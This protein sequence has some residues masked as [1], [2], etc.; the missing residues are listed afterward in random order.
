MLVCVMGAV[1]NP[2]MEYDGS[3]LTVQTMT[4]VVRVIMGTNIS[5]GTDFTE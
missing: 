3:V 1:C 2:Y 5:C 4:C